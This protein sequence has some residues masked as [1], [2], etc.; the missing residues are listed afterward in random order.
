[1]GEGLADQ[2]SDFAANG[3]EWRTRPLSG[4]G[5]AQTVNPLAGFVHDGRTRTRMLGQTIL[6]HGGKA[7]KSK[8]SFRTMSAAERAALV[9]F[10]KSH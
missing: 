1:M 8:Q 6:W 3:R 5:Q 10:L 2:R 7:E 9:A 4:I